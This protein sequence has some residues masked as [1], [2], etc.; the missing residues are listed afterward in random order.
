MPLEDELDDDR[1]AP[2]MKLRSSWY[3]EEEIDTFTQF[4]NS[5]GDQ[6]TNNMLAVA[7]KKRPIVHLFPTRKLLDEG[8][9]EDYA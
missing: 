5:L 8:H 4:A 3:F 9:H 7:Y 1:L 6:T 2:T